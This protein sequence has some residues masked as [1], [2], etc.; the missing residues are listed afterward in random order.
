MRFKL[1]STSWASSHTHRSSRRSTK[2]SNKCRRATPMSS[3][4]RSWG[5][6]FRSL[7]FWVGVESVLALRRLCGRSVGGGF[8]GGRAPSD[9]SVSTSPTRFHQNTIVLRPGHLLLAFFP[10]WPHHRIL[11]YMSR[12]HVNDCLNEGVWKVVPRRHVWF[13]W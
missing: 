5:S 1:A 11:Q 10:R 6:A 12:K 4:A 8:K 2:R 7:T 13:A 9:S 3:R